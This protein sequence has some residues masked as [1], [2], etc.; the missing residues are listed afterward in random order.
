MF[1]GITTHRFLAGIT[2][3]L[4]FAALLTAHTLSGMAKESLAITLV[5]LLASLAPLLAA[6][7]K[8]SGFLDLGFSVAQG[9]DRV[10]D[11]QE[12]VGAFGHTSLLEAVRYLR[13]TNGG[14]LR[15]GVFEQ[16]GPG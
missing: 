8:F 16:Y 14:P 9:H 6:F 7:L 15:L 12:I 10:L 1:S 13:G 5:A 11:C 4:A 2:I 3:C